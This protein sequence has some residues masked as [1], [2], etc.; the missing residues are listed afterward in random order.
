MSTIQ[1]LCKIEIRQPEPQQILV[2]DMPVKERRKLSINNETIK[3]IQGFSWEDLQ[4]LSFVFEED[5][6]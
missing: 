4:G 3:S 6:L 1:S 5:E 2:E